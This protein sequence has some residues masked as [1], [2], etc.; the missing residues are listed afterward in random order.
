M[1]HDLHAI[2]RYSRAN[3]RSASCRIV[4]GEPLLGVVSRRQPTSLE[5]GSGLVNFLYRSSIL[6]ANQIAEHTI[7]GKVRAVFVTFNA[8]TGLMYLRP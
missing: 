5:K 4:L 1:S 3:Q 6:E 7:V 2:L 8:I